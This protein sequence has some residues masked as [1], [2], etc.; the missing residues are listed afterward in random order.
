MIC[1]SFDLFN[2]RSRLLLDPSYAYKVDN[3][4][5]VERNH[6]RLDQEFKTGG[7]ILCLYS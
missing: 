3:W 1:R 5:N 6:V 4:Y 2:K 7:S